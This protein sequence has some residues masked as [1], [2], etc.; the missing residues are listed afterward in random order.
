MRACRQER[1]AQEQG[2]QAGAAAHAAGLA[3]AEAQQRARLAG[4]AA[5]QAR[6]DAARLR[7]QHA[8]DARL[9][10]ARSHTRACC[11][12]PVLHPCTRRPPHRAAPPSAAPMHTVPAP[13]RRADTHTRA[14]P[15]SPFCIPVMG[16]GVIA[17]QCWSDGPP[18]CAIEGVAGASRSRVV[19]GLEITPLMSPMVP[20][21][22]WTSSVTCWGMLS[23]AVG[24]S[25]P[26]CRAAQRLLPACV[27]R[28]GWGAR[29]AEAEAEAAAKLERERALVSQYGGT[30]AELS[31]D[32]TALAA[33]LQAAREEGSRLRAEAEARRADVE[34]LQV[35][36]T[37]G[38]RCRKRSGMHRCR[39]RCRTLLEEA[40][41]HLISHATSCRMRSACRCCRCMRAC[42]S[43]SRRCA[44][45]GTHA[46]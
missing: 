13:P 6:A 21:L 29:L 17:R 28:S 16:T 9:A 22:S 4:D 40:M 39:P 27:H 35:R 11:S 23:H 38:A 1:A 37:S 44:W 33:D 46:P 34:R 8:Q 10:E 3:L 31:R 12:P 26:A 41:H 5:E 14:A 32:G 30:L 19:A 45:E 25:T 43:S 24:A 15:P 20:V 18:A 7:A 36:A 2:L 42:S